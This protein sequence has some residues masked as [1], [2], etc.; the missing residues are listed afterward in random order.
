MYTARGTLEAI[1]VPHVP[2]L[3]PAL[4]CSAGCPASLLCLPDEAFL[5]IEEWSNSKKL[6]A[7]V[8]NPP[9]SQY[10]LGCVWVSAHWLHLSWFQGTLSKSRRDDISWT[11]YVPN[12]DGWLILQRRKFAVDWIA[13]GLPVLQRLRPGALQST[14]MDSKYASHFSPVVFG[15]NPN[16]PETHLTHLWNGDKCATARDH[17]YIPGSANKSTHAVLTVQY[18]APTGC[19][20]CSLVL[21]CVAAVRAFHRNQGMK[22]WFI[23]NQPRENARHRKLQVIKHRWW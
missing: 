17:F 14:S 11:L 9:T 2:S 5:S 16:F 21:Q 20:I 18:L 1:L 13:G 3:S 10:K 6:T 8:L 12:E 23:N 7:Q 22:Q 19:S 4:P 15:S